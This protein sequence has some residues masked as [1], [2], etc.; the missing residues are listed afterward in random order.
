[1]DK[2]EKEGERNK[3]S[4][5]V[6]RIMTDI[7]NESGLHRVRPER[8]VVLTVGAARTDLRHGYAGEK[9]EWIRRSIPRVDRL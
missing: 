3:L 9:P 4:L 8:A 1:M 2:K 6:V 5:T 7:R